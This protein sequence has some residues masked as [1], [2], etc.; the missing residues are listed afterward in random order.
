MDPHN[1]DDDVER[2]HEP[3][4]DHLE[5]GRLGHHLVD[6]GLD[7]G[8]DHHCGDGNHDSILEKKRCKV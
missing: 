6:G 7:G 2:V 3:V 5:V 8:D 1:D 4:V